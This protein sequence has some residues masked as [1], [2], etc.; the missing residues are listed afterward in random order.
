MTS[1]MSRSCGRDSEK[2]QEQEKALSLRKFVF[3]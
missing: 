1:G 3:A 2:T